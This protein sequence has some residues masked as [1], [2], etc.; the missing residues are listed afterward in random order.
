MPTATAEA[1]P[2]VPEQSQ[3]PHPRSSRLLWMTTIATIVLGSAASILPSTAVNV[4]VP[5][6]ERVFNASLTDVQW[7]LTAYLLGLSAVIPASGWLADRFGT[8]AVY[9]VSLVTFSVASILCGLAWSVH[10]E[11]AFRVL[12]GMAGGT[13]QP[14]GMAFLTRNTPP[15]RRGRM[16]AVL[17]VPLLLAPALGPTIGGWLIEYWDWRLVFWANVPVALLSLLLGFFV[18]RR[19]NQHHRA[20]RLDVVGMLLATPGVAALIFGMTQGPSRGW[21]SGL[22]VGA[23]AAGAFLLAAFVAWEVRQ[24]APLLDLAVFRDRGFAAA[25][26]VS[27][28]VAMALFGAVFLV[29]V[30]MQQVQ[31]FSTLDAGLLLAPQGLAAA[32]VMP[33]SGTLTDRIGPRPVVLTGIMLLFAATLWMAQAD[34]STPRATWVG[35]LALRGVGMGFSMMPAFA[36]AYITLAPQAIGRATALANTLQRIFSSFGIAVLA[37]IVASRVTAHVAEQPHSA[38]NLKVAAARGFDDTLY[39]AAALVL[40]ALPGALFLARARRRAPEEALAA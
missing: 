14:V 21:T 6:F 5:D 29:P 22:V 13:I 16:M 39:V 19:D 2:S 11:I 23:L 15:E 27:A 24:P 31:G 18:L 10:S 12:Q 30:F 17:G 26:V 35:M 28:G 36:A 20:G 4:A 9:L 37:T 7:V 40:L 32:L 33:I 38:T 34:P 8:R 25:M 1:R 3:P